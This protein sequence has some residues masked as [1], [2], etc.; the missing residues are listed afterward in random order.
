MS[1]AEGLDVLVGAAGATFSRHLFRA[2]HGA[3]TVAPR[4]GEAAN[5]AERRLVAPAG[6]HVGVAELAGGVHELQQGVEPRQV[7][8]HVLDGR[9][10]RLCTQAQEALLSSR[11]PAMRPRSR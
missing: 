5:P 2:L 9:C 4:C 8:F 10:R 1:S 7:L 6:V 3:A 11:K